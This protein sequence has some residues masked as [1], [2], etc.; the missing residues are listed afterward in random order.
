LA[1]SASLLLASSLR[2][3]PISR[4]REVRSALGLEALGLR[5][6]ER[7]SFLSCRHSTFHH[8]QG[9]R[10]W[11]WWVLGQPLLLVSDQRFTSHLQVISAQTW[12]DSLHQPLPWPFQISIPISDFAGPCCSRH[13][14][15]RGGTCLVVDH[16]LAHP[17]DSNHGFQVPFLIVPGLHPGSDVLVGQKS[18]SLVPG[19]QGLWGWSV[20]SFFDALGWLV[21]LIL[22]FGWALSCGGRPSDAGGRS[23]P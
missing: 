8:P 6:D 1:L 17:P 4:C 12:K 7:T 13:G 23:Q 19:F 16:P 22:Y 2:R 20:A 11:L 14:S 18:V 15:L 5:S 21:A 3:I 9:S 10:L